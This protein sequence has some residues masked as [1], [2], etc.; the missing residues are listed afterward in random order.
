MIFNI[1]FMLFYDIATWMNFEDN[2]G[3]SIT[4][5]AWTCFCML[6]NLSG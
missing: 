6:R 4:R 2:A 5:G 3:K 1:F